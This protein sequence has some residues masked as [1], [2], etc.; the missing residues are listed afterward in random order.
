MLPFLTATGRTSELFLERVY[1]GL[2]VF[3]L[4]PFGDRPAGLLV[5]SAQN[6]THGVLKQETRMKPDKGDQRRKGKKVN[7]TQHI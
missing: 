6:A 5:V 2:V 7:A 3:F 1:E 4:E